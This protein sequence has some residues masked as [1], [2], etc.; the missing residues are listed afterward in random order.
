M[1]KSALE[2]IVIDYIKTFISDDIATVL[3]YP[4]NEAEFKNVT[5]KSKIY[6][7]FGGADYNKPK[8]TA[9]SSQEVTDKLQIWLIAKKRRATDGTNTLY[10]LLCDNLIGYTP[11]NYSRLF[12]LK[13]D[14]HGRENGAFFYCFEIGAVIKVV[15]N[16]TPIDG[17]K[18]QAAG[19]EFEFLPPGPDP[20]N[21]QITEPVLP[22]PEEP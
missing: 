12:G 1:N 15:Q 14:F 8:S 3:P 2:D 9:E 13:Y 21:G 11:A 10:A 5:T 22:L 17:V 20:S 4:D 18:V 7:G 19:P 16:F 6:V